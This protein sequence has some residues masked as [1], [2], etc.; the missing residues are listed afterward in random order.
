MSSGGSQP[1]GGVQCSLV[2]LQSGE[3]TGRG[4]VDEVREVRKCGLGGCRTF[5]A[6]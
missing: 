4:T 2:R 5:G 1:G 6:L 3:Q